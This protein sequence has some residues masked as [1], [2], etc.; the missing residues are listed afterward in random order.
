[1]MSPSCFSKKRH[2]FRWEKKHKCFG[3]L[4]FLVIIEVKKKPFSAQVGVPPKFTVPENTRKDTNKTQNRFFPNCKHQKFSKF[5]FPKSFSRKKVCGEK[6]ALS[7]SN[8]FFPVEITFE[9]KEVP[10]DR[11]KL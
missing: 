6:G 8:A 4:M 7:S 3:F 11:M 1:M 10:F 9:S 5:I 2:F